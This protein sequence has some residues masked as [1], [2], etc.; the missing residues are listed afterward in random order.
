MQPC[1]SGWRVTQGERSVETEIEIEKEVYVMALFG[2]LCSSLS[3]NDKIICAKRVDA[4]H[5]WIKHHG[6]PERGKFYVH[7]SQFPLCVRSVYVMRSDYVRSR[8]S[9]FQ[10][11]CL[12][13]HKE[14]QNAA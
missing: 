4:N 1:C 9:E 13:A 8:T 6:A 5:T 3:R 2:W 12:Q 10:C 7:S 14:E 11:V